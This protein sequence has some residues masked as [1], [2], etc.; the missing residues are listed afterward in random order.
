MSK[1][2]RPFPIRT[3]QILALLSDEG[4]WTT[5]EV[6]GD[7]GVSR[8][9]ARDVLERMRSRREVTKARSGRTIEVGGVDRELN[10]YA[11]TITDRGFKRH[12]YLD[13]RAERERKG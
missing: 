13:K 3:Y 1:R 7:L 6:A 12:K 9:L 8:Q 4:A 11:Y 10:E 5:M 2:K